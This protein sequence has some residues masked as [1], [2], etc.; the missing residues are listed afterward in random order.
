M[1]F[2]YKCNFKVSF[3][4]DTYPSETISGVVE[5]NSFHLLVKKA[6]H[7]ASKA[8]QSKFWWTSANVV[9]LDKIT[10]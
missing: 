6:A 1:K 4:S 8:R 7:Q 2:K 5:A 3:E 9:L 10:Q